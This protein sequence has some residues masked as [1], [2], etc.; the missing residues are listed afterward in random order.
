MKISRLAGVAALLAAGFA[1]AQEVKLNAIVEFWYTQ[2]M[3]SN[4]RLNSA[5]PGGYMTNPSLDAAF[6]EN[7]FSH[8]RTEIYLNGK[9]TDKLTW[10]VMFDP[11]NS[12][13]TVGNNILNDAWVNYQ[14]TPAF[15]LKAGQFKP[16][17]TWE[18]SMV[19]TAGFMFYQ[20]SLGS[21][22]VGD[23]RDR[24]IVATYGFGDAKGFNGKMNLGIFNGTSDDGSA[25]KNADANAQKDWV[26]RLEMGFGSDH[27]FGTYYREG[28]TAV[29]D[30]GLP[31]QTGWTGA[32][33]V[34]APTS[35]QILDNKDKT[36][37]LG[38][39]Y[40]YETSKWQ[41]SAEVITGLLGR[42]NATVFLVATPAARQ[43]LDQKYMAYTFSGVYKM[44]NHQITARYDYLN[45][46]E[47]DDWYSATNPYTTTV[48][49]GVATG[50]DYSPKYTEAILGYNYVFNPAKFSFAK[51]KVNY[52]MRS[53]NF[54]QPRTSAGQIGEQGGNS[55]VA[56]IMVGF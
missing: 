2:M 42:R 15:G 37:N 52:I 36:T 20:R 5:A 9:M 45:Y 28:V 18:A 31:V 41:A 24:G 33:Y 21:R 48:A 51:L 55:V 29:K 13:S 3:D 44:G 39:Y 30:F 26:A 10:G 6:K 22:L 16:L 46:N 19:G 49:T 11:N 17:Q 14:F 38:A 54:L 27:K 23:R 34:N 1:Q 35:T 7:Q 12:T 47:G 4:L 40:V 50:N 25:G 56:S 8:R 32:G 43:H 53:D